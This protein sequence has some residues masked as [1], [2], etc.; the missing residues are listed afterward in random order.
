MRYTCTKCSMENGAS[1]RLSEESASGELVCSLNPKHRFRI[2][3]SGFL[4]S[5]PER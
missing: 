2:G 4:E 3:K 1:V 5:L